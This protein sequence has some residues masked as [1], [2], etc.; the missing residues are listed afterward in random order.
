MTSGACSALTPPQ[1]P[2]AHDIHSPSILIPTALARRLASDALMTPFSHPPTPDLPSRHTSVHGSEIA[3][4][5]WPLCMRAMACGSNLPSDIDWIC[6]SPPSNLLQVR[7]SSSDL[8]LIDLSS[9]TR[10][11]SSL[12][13]FERDPSLAL[14][15]TYDLDL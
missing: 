2:V 13:N 3:Y 7:N 12:T 5:P 14:H 10:L 1:L 8:I 6:T 11:R 9:G 4:E 15:R